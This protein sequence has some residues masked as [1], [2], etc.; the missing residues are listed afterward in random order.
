MRK[1]GPADEPVR[2]QAAPVAKNYGEALGNAVEVWG[3]RVS[4]AS[5]AGILKQYELIREEVTTSL[6]IQQQTLSF[7]IA[8]I[9]ILAAG[10]FV[11]E[12][13]RFRSN[14]LVIFLP[15]IAYLA[16][17]IWFSEVMRMLR[18][19]AY[20]MTLEKKLDEEGGDGSLTWEYTVAKGRVKHPAWK[21]YF[22]V[23]DPDQLRLLAVTL[24][25][26]ILAAASIMVGW[27]EASGYVQVFAVVAGV[28][29][30]IVLSLLYQLRIDQ[31]EELLEIDPDVRSLRRLRR[32]AERLR[33]VPPARAKDSDVPPT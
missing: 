18:A 26:L 32:L 33:L 14:L 1:A 30:L 3:E 29:A 21:P 10:A 15:L 25:F 28:L 12:E 23:L 20:L 31:L 24:L 13:D 9:G 19:G 6:A 16:V 8:T 4:P 2:G 11:A 5:Q 7:G 27:N 22:G 17:T